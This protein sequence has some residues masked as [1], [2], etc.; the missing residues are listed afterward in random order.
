MLAANLDLAYPQTRGERPP[1]TQE[2]ARYFA[3]FDQ[4]QIEDIEV[5]RLEMEVFQLM[6]PL[7]ALYEEPLR[8]RALARM[9]S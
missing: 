2:R 8:G 6:R 7:S 3:A 5:Q 9:L 4:L 1:Q